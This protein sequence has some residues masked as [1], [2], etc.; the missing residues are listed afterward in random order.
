M[1]AFDKIYRGRNPKQIVVI[2]KHFDVQD[3]CLKHRLGCG[4]QILR[5]IQNMKLPFL[6]GYKIMPVFL[7]L[8]FSMSGLCVFC[9]MKFVVILA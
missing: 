5:C 2:S 1:L 7:Q 4:V 8:R 6:N 3:Q 9:S